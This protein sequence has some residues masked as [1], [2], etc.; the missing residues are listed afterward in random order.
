MVRVPRPKD[1]GLYRELRLRGDE[2]GYDNT[3][4]FADEKRDEKTVVFI[5]T[6]RADDAA[7][8][9]YYLERV[10]VDTPR[11]TISIVAQLPS[12]TITLEKPSS[13]PLVIVTSETSAA[14]ARVL[15]QYVQRRGNTALRG[16]RRQA[17]PRRS[18]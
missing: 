3:I 2:Q 11:R 15:E 10:F 16:H 4:Y 8:L 17:A 9:L 5:G 18:A 1:S 13:V 14:N 6:D 12:K 7:G